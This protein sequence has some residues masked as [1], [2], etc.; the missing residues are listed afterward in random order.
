MR[1]VIAELLLTF[2][3]IRIIREA[4]RKAKDGRIDQSDFL[5]HAASSSRYGTF[6]P[7][8]TSIIFHFAGRG[9]PTSRLALLDFAQLLNP[10]WQAPTETTTTSSKPEVYSLMSFLKGFAHSAYNFGLGGVAGA[11]GATIVYPIDLGKVL[12][13]S[14]W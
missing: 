9:D 14:L 2:H 7:M 10:R 11:F 4:T 6:S 5:N 13:S 3:S 12:N 8:E 1:E